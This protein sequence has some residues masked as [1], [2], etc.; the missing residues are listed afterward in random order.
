MNVTIADEAF[1][2]YLN[3][4]NTDNI[5]TLITSWILFVHFDAFDQA[6]VEAVRHGAGF[7]ISVCRRDRSS[8]TGVWFSDASGSKESGDVKI[9]G[10]WSEVP[11]INSLPEFLTTIWGL[12]VGIYFWLVSK[13]RERERK[14]PPLTLWLS[15][16]IRETNQHSSLRSVS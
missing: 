1:F 16:S 4:W 9:I 6:R 11:E 10:L 7:F 15:L 13:K 5:V 12:R 14:K 8:D 3:E 2:P